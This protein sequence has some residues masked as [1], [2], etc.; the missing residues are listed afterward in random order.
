MIRETD[1]YDS[2]IL[3]ILIICTQQAK[4]MKAIFIC[5]SAINHRNK[6]ENNIFVKY[7]N[8]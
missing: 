2:Y 6:I 5:I 4:Q 7:F 8:Y 3:H 1:S